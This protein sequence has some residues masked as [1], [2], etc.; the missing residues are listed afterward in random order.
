MMPMWEKHTFV[1]SRKGGAIT[2][3]RRPLWQLSRRALCSSFDAELGLRRRAM[4]QQLKH[5]KRREPSPPPERIDGPV[6]RMSTAM[7]R[8]NAADSLTQV[9]LEEAKPLYENTHG[10]LGSYL[11]FDRD[12]TRG[13]S[14]TLWQDEA[15]MDAAASNSAYASTMARLGSHFSGAPDTE[16]WRLRASFLPGDSSESDGK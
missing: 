8:D 11:L 15:A 1:F 13:R 4:T 7:L 10:F 5:L 12:Y 16:V 2:M 9:Y 6:A 14:I 3:S